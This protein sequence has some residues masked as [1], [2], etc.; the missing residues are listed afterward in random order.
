MGL[1]SPGQKLIDL[2][3]EVL[4]AA[5]GA[6]HGG[7][8]EAVIVRW[9]LP[10]VVADFSTAY[11]TIARLLGVWKVLRAEQVDVDDVTGELADWLAE[12]AAMRWPDLLD[13]LTDPAT[14]QRWGATVALVR[15]AGEWLFHRRKKGNGEYTSCMGP[16]FF[17]G[18]L[19]YSWCDLATAVVTSNQVPDTAQA[20]RLAPHGIEPRLQAVTFPGG[21]VFDPNDEEAD[22]FAF[23]HRFRLASRGNT[24]LADYAQLRRERTAK[25]MGSSISYGNLARY[26]RPLVEAKTD[27]VS[28]LDPWGEI[29]ESPTLHPEQAGPDT[30]PILASN[31]TAGCRLVMAVLRRSAAAERVDIAA[32]LTDAAIIPANTGGGVVAC[33]GGH[34]VTA[35]GTAG[36]RL[37]DR[38]TLCRLLRPFD[39]F[40]LDAASAFKLIHG[41]D[42]RD[43]DVTVYGRNRYLVIDPVTNEVVHDSEFALGGVFADPAYGEELLTDGR[44]RWVAEAVTVVA[45]SDTGAGPLPLIRIASFGRAMAVSPFTI[46]GPEQA[47]WFDPGVRPFTRALAAHVDPFATAEMLDADGKPD[48]APVALYDPDPEAWRFLDWRGR[49]GSRTRPLLHV[50]AVSTS[51][52]T[53]V[54][55]RIDDVLGDWCQ[56]REPGAR[57][58]GDQRSR[59]ARGLLTRV[60]AQ[61]L[62]GVDLL[63]RDGAQ[64]VERQAGIVRPDEVQTVYRSSTTTTA[65]AGVDG[66]LV[67]QMVDELGQVKVAVLAGITRRRLGRLLT[68]QPAKPGTGPALINALRTR[69][70]LDLA[71]W[72]ADATLVEAPAEV[73][74][75]EF[76]ALRSRQGADRMCAVPGCGA[77]ARTGSEY[78]STAH[79]QA[80]SRRRLRVSRQCPVRIVP[81]GRKVP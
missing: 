11:P 47:K 41:T 76:L 29:F 62:P 26:D 61:A 1:T 5:L 19:P 50:G 10:A 53:F 7:L 58:A 23:L 71:E 80:A 18:L 46:T 78:C 56:G 73:V 15:P 27:T 4:G 59:T 55:K 24:S 67:G 6:F 30:C 33:P 38:A 81:T 3:P 49:D 28:V 57:A 8:T 51:Q 52:D 14:W 37:L 77:A 39:R 70:L 79:R 21:M 22:L 31:V 32:V 63:G 12:L 17:D 34:H 75:T 65:I 60:P 35:V 16:L 43:L 68:S 13:T 36:V 40:A 2:P 45:V 44:R 48:G 66:A 54:P 42:S 9:R 72:G 25:T 64:L 20:W 74:F 69:A